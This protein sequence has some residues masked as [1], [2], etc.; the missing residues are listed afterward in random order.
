MKKNT[1]FLDFLYKCANKD[2]KS[3]DIFVERYSKLI[4]NYIIRALE[5]YN[6]PFHAD[7]VEDIFIS[8][9]LGLLDKDCRKL[10]NFRGHNERS[11]GAYI[12]EITF[13]ITIDFLRKQRRSVNYEEIQNI[14]SDGKINE[15]LNNMELEEIIFMLKGRLPERQKYLFKLIYE[16]GWELSEVT[17]IMKLK[18]NAV[19][20]LKHRMINKLIKFAKEE[21][22]RVAG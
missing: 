15:K 12:R 2:K 21:H 3:W 4:Y 22:L 11:F 10:K 19:C 16:K 13:N 20:Q 1:E 5:I 17:D 6:Y 7:E 18:L 9:F 14:I 8:V